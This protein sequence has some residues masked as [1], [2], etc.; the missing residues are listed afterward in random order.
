[1][2]EEVITE[3]FKDKNDAAEINNKNGVEWY[4]F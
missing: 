1:M 2:R 3:K 4:R